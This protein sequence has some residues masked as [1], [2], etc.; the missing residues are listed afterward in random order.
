MGPDEAARKF[1]DAYADIEATLERAHGLGSDV[2]G[3]GDVV[4]QTRSKNAVVRRYGNHLSAFRELH[5]AIS[6]N[7]YRDGAPIATP[8]PE[9]VSA[10]QRVRDELMRPTVVGSR[11]R[12]SDLY[13]V[14][15]HDGVQD[16]LSNMLD[17][18]Y[19]QAP[20]FDESGYAGLLT[21]NAI[22][23][24]VAH[25]MD[26]RG[27]VLLEGATVQTVMRWAEEHE[28]AELVARTLSIA[29]A[30]EKLQSPDSP[31]VLLVPQIGQPSEE[32]LGMLVALDAP[33]LLE[34]LR[35]TIG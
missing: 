32:P 7:R 1:L 31:R 19:S 15:L 11:V 34:E 14:G 18:S 13:K 3:L 26:E 29:A 25:A 4:R 21:T 12:K 24:W 8:L 16:H 22:A 10:V 23:R 6:H 30:L 33:R 2:R 35:V 27:D 17:R 20:V 5:N 9:T 28:Q